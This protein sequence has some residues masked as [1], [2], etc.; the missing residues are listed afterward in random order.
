MRDVRFL[1]NIANPYNGALYAELN[2]IGC[3]TEV[4]YKS[5]PIG[6]GRTWALEPQPYERIASPLRDLQVLTGEPARD[7]ILSGGY[8]RTRDVMRTSVSACTRTRLS[9]WGERLQQERSLVG[10]RLAQ[11]LLLRPMSSILAIGTWARDSYREVLPPQT[12]IHIFPY[13]LPAAT[14]RP[15]RSDE[16]LLGYAGSLITRKGVAEFLYATAALSCRLPRL[17]VVGS[18]PERHRLHQLA[19]HLKLDVSWYDEVDKPKLDALRSRWWAQVVPSRYDG[20]GMVVPEA[21]AAGIPVIATDQVG[22]ARDLV[23]SSL[24]GELAP[25][26][27]DLPTAIARLLEPSYQADL[28]AGARILGREL[29]ADRAARW[30]HALLGDLTGREQSFIADATTAARK[31]GLPVDAG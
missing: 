17:E 11:G 8:H 9:F 3:S 27:A 20:W 25:T 15:N 14:V 2:A 1:S 7:T 18:G 30:L 10:V 16:P 22:A 13:G 6:E 26:L 31:A 21:L 24:T 29:V 4:L 12:P 28:S 19:D 23:I 5:E